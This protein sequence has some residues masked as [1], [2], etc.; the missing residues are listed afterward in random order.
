M[1]QIEA[2][3]RGHLEQ[4]QFS[5]L[6]Q[7]LPAELPHPQADRLDTCC[8]VYLEGLV[9][10][11]RQLSEL[12]LSLDTAYQAWFETQVSG[13]LRVWWLGS[14]VE[15]E[16]WCQQ[17]LGELMLVLERAYICLVHGLRRRRGEL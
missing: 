14:G 3:F 13:T 1:P 17:Q 6:P 12:V 4:A 10:N 11:Q 8:G 2:H 5:W 15:G 16:G 7:P 9:S